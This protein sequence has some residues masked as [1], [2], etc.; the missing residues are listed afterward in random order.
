MSVRK[1]FIVLITI[2]VCVILGAFVLN[3][4]MPNAVTA[5]VDAVEATIYQAT[6]MKLDFNGDGDASNYTNQAATNNT[7][8]GDISDTENV[9]S[10]AGVAGYK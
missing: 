10:G 5:V 8:G 6:G 7:F 1:I 3:V 4:L 9:E 2:V